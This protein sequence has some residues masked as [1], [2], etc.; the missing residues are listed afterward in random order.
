MMNLMISEE[1]IEEKEKLE[2][3]REKFSAVYARSV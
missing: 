1:Y 3:K 2:K